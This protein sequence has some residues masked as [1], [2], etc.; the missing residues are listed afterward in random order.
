MPR[1]NKEKDESYH[2]AVSKDDCYRMEARQ[3]WR[4]KRVNGNESDDSSKIFNV[5]CVFYGETEFP[6]SPYDG[7]HDNDD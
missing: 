7:D 5:D 3:G 1:Y 4:L 6:A 2:A